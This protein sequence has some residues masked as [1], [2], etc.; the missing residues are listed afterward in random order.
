[1]PPF[2]EGWTD[3]KPIPQAETENPLVPINYSPACMPLPNLT[4]VTAGLHNRNWPHLSTSKTYSKRLMT[5]LSI[6]LALDVSAMSTFR[7]ILQQEEL[8]KRVLELTAEIVKINP[9]H[10]TVWYGYTASKCA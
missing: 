10:Y 6:L 9:A 7:Y 4:L 5:D 2:Q 8:S 1:M 3:V